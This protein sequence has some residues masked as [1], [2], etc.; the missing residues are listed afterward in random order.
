MLTPALGAI[1][2]Y[3]L[4]FIKNAEAFNSGKVTDFDAVGIRVID[5]RTLQTTLARPAPYL[6][7]LVAHSTWF[8]TSRTT[9]EKSGRTNARDTAWT[10]P[11]N[12][13]GNGAFV[14]IEWRRNARIVV[15]KNTRYW[16]AAQNH[17]ELAPPP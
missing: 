8:A 3:M 15:T 10:R 6:L 2:A 12:F 1:Y 7:A 14:L 16:N 11:G 13:V 17:I 4:W 9:V 5:D